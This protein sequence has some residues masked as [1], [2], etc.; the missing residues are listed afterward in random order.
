MI[1]TWFYSGLWSSTTANSRFH[2]RR[3]PL[4]GFNIWQEALQNPRICLIC[5]LTPKTISD[6]KLYVVK[7]LFLEKWLYRNKITLKVLV[8]R[9]FN[10][11]I[12]NNFDPEL[13]S[14]L[15]F[16]VYSDKV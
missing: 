12:M 14:F 1:I 6:S 5:I 4:T 13:Q 7:G 3:S 2:N 10:T 9:V 8:R 16:L 11:K 15:D